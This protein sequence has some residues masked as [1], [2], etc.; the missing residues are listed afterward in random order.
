M[1]SLILS[2][3][4]ISSWLL[5]LSLASYGQSLDVGLDDG[6]ALAGEDAA[7]GLFQ[8]FVFYAECLLG[9]T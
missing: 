1:F 5:L 7:D 4:D 6:V 2:L 3:N 9:S 8:L